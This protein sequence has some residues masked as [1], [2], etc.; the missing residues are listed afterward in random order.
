MP[1]PSEVEKDISYMPA[2]WLS[3][4]RTFLCICKGKVKL[5]MDTFK[6]QKPSKESN[7]TMPR[8]DHTCLHHQQLRD[9][10]HAKGTSRHH[11][12]KNTSSLTKPRTS[13]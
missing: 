9:I 11:K 1:F 5:I 13:F 6:A 10:H 2:S 4:I 3:K 12:S 7:P 8:C